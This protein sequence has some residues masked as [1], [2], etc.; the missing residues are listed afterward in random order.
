M[1]K[2][3]ILC[4]GNSCRSVLGEALI[5]HLAGDR[6]QA[7]SAG[8]RPLGKINANALATLKRNGIATEGFISQSWNEFADEGI[9]IAI[10]VC[11]SAAG[12]ACPVYLNSTVRGHWG[13]TDP[14]HISGSEEEVAAAFQVTYNALKKRIEQL[15]ALPFE[16]MPTAEL[17]L[18]L[19]K[20]GAEVA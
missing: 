7:F 16:T 6:L 10:T 5:N 14:A 19:N 15:L 1:L 18:A 9:D 13:L 2:I 8:S 17:S 20:I 4:T 3:L 11:D 12:E